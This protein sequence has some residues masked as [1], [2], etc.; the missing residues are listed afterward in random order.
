MTAPDLGEATIGQLISLDGRAAV[1]T[2]AGQGIGRA[3]AR[4]YAEAGANVV[5]ADL[6]GEAA[7]EAATQLSEQFGVEVLG[8]AVDVTS[9][10]SVRELAASV[11]AHFGRLDI[12]ANLAAVYPM[13]EEQF[14][15]LL[16][17]PLEEW[18]RTLTIN[19]TGSFL[20]SQA[21][22]REMVAAGNGGVIINT[23]TT[24]VDRYPGHIGMV[25]YSASKGGIEQLTKILAGELGPRGIRAYALKPTV[26]A[27]EGMAEHLVS[28]SRV[29]GVEEPFAELAKAMPLRRLGL[30]DDIARVALFAASDLS[31]F[32]TGCV[33]PADG[34]E[35][36][37]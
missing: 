14:V 26:V 13:R 7:A 1:V 25:A 11:A 20:C 31:A 24:V 16:D 6:N 22:A 23:T 5:V 4:R 17:F 9:R 12:W 8:R 30:P 37:V 33:L 27:T 15:D 29:M 36:L 35:L 34:G 32:M 21:A 28:L 3:V 2:G 19:L 18:E 10:E